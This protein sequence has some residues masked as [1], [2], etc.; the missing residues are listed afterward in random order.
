MSGLD[1]EKTRA[2]QSSSTYWLTAVGSHGLRTSLKPKSLLQGSA[3]GGPAAEEGAPEGLELASAD[4]GDGE[5]PREISL[6]MSFLGTRGT[7]S[8]PRLSP[9]SSSSGMERRALDLRQG[10][11]FPFSSKVAS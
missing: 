8:P 9:A 7:F 1:G 4:A 2:R 10:E 5:D 11:V 3:S 6:D